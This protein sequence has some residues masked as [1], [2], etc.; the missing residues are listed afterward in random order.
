MPIPADLVVEVVSPTD[1]YFGVVAK[2]NDYLAN[3]FPLI[4]VVDP[5]ARTV[6][7]YRA[8]QAS[9]TILHESDEITA[10]PALAAFRCRV[11]E[12]FE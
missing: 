3:G 12:F 8:G 7:V 5:N 9:P 11:A 6:T 4:W 2:V 10:E 1:L